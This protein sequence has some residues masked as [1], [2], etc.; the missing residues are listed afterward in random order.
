MTTPPEEAP[1]SATKEEIA[2]KAYDLY[3]KEGCQQGHCQKYWHMAEQELASNSGD[4]QQAGL[5]MRNEGGAAPA[6]QRG[7]IVAPHVE[8]HWSGSKNLLHPL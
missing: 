3:V 4:T 5:D 7:V 8:R 6:A 2:Q 1:M